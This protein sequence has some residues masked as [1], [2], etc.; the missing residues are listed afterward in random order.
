MG[1]STKNM[2]EFQQEY[3][4]AVHEMGKIIVTR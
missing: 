3:H 4:K 2:G 1:T